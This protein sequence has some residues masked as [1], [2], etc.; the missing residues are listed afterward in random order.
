MSSHNISQ[1]L[2]I[3]STQFWYT[4][5]TARA[6]AFEVVELAQVGCFTRE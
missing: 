6:V 5:E 3:P 4:D 2:L 1:L